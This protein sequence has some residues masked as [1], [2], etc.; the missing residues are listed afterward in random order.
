MNRSTSELLNR[1]GRLA[2]VHLPERVDRYRA[3]SAE[4]ARIGIDINSPKVCLPPAPRPSDANGFHSP[5]VYGNFLSHLEILR[6]AARDGLESVWIIEDDAIFSHR[7][8]RTQSLIVKHL[9]EGERWDICF[10]GHSVSR[11]LPRSSSGFVRFNG[12]FIWA[13]CYAVG[14]RALPRLIGYLEET[15]QNPPGHPDGG[16]MYIDAALTFFRR[17]NPDLVSLVSSP[18]FSVQAGSPSSLNNMHWYDRSSLTRNAVGIARRFRDQCWR[19]GIHRMACG[20]E[21]SD[22]A[23]RSASPWPPTAAMD[24]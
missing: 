17:R 21:T 19:F 11:R 1:F 22:D 12:P 23:I 5:G 6:A 2:I 18:C 7:F 10:F 4:L 16:R 8:V 9:F 14:A 3:L 24:R 13:H 15:L 20:L